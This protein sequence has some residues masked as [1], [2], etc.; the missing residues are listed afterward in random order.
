MQIAVRRLAL[1]LFIFIAF[2]AWADISGARNCLAT[3]CAL[4]VEG[5]ITSSDVAL[6]KEAFERAQGSGRL[7][8][9]LDSEGGD[10]AAAIEIGRLIRRWPDSIALVSLNSKCFS[11]C[12]FVL[13]GGLHRTVHGKVGI[14]RP[15]GAGQKTGTY[16][17]TQKDFRAIEQSAKRFF[18]DV[19]I[20]VSLFDEMMSVPPQKLRILTEQEL[21]RYGIGQNDP[22][23]DEVRDGQAAQALGI[24]KEE[25][26]R[27]KNR[28]ER[29]CNALSVNERKA[30]L[31][32][33]DSESAHISAACKT[34]VLRAESDSAATKTGIRDSKGKQ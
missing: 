23:Y 1:A 10:I 26:L 5:R 3:S 2:P 27:R 19:N 7:L 32:V 34:A 25:Y 12:V 4:M 15:F 16:E 13:A 14:H 31:S 8:L 30:G 11:A 33:S 17:S 18:Q 21:A 20:P 9:M 28:S 29:I 6:V 22:V 24:S